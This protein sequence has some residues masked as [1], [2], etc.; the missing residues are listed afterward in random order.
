MRTAHSHD[1][2]V[3]YD[4]FT[5]YFFFFD[6]GFDW[7]QQSSVFEGGSTPD[8]VRTFE[9]R[10]YQ[11]SVTPTVCTAQTGLLTGFI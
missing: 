6:D 7:F 3:G 9:F 2:F 4:S 1:E 8:Y 11:C 5:K 10:S